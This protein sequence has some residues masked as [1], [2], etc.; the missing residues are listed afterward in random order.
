MAPTSKKR[1]HDGMDERC[2]VDDE[3]S[4]RP[5]VHRCVRDAVR[6]RTGLHRLGVLEVRGRSTRTGH[7]L[8]P[9]PRIH[10][11][12]DREG[13][14]GDVLGRHRPLPRLVPR[15]QD[16]G[17]PA[18]HDNL[19]ARRRSVVLGGVQKPDRAEA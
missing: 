12:L 18:Q 1:A 11:P 16:V 9:R 10:R 17:C 6:S 15:L 3:G 8:L 13:L 2:V 19:D 7:H 14:G 4:D 5:R